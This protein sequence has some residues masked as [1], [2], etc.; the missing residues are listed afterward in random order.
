MKRALL[1]V[2][3]FYSCAP[4]ARLTTPSGKPEVTIIGISTPFILKDIDTWSSRN[5]YAVAERTDTSISTYLEGVILVENWQ[6]KDIPTRDVYI[7]PTTSVYTI[8]RS[9]DTATIYLRR[10]DTKKRESNGMFSSEDQI[11]IKELTSRKDLEAMQK[12]LEDVAKFINI[13]KL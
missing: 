3:L 2:I 13:R 8:R 5:G 7:V 9:G 12:D 4:P 1:F 11:V 6:K 10:F